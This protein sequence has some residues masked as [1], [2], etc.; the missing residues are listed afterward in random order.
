ME[1]RRSEQPIE[2]QLA[3]VNPQ[4]LNSCHPAQLPSPP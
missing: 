3:N 1:Q 2:D 4:Q